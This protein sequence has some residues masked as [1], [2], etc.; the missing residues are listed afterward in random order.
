MQVPTVGASVHPPLLCKG[1]TLTPLRAKMIYHMQ[2][3]RLAPKTQAAS[4]A[5]VAGLATF[6][7]R[8]PDQLPPAQMRRSL[9]PGLVDRHRA[10]SSCN[11]VACGLRFFSTKTLGWEPL[12]L[13]L[14]PRTGRSQ[15]PQVLSVEE[16]QRLFTSAK[17]PRNRVLLMTTSAAGLRVSAVVRLKRTD[18]ASERGLSR[19]EP[20]KGRKD[21]STRLSTRLLTDLRASWKLSRPAPWLLTGLD[22]HAPLP[23]GTAQNISYHAP[24]TAGITHGHGIHTL[25][26]GCATHRLEAGVDV[27]TIQMVL[28]HQA[29]DTPARSLRITRQHLATIRSPCDLLPCGDPPLPTPEEPHAAAYHRLPRWGS[30]APAQRPTVGSRR[31]LPPLWCDLPPYPSRIALAAAG[32]ARYR[33]LPDG[34]ARWARR[35]LSSL[36][37]RAVRLSCLSPSPRSEVSDVYQDAVG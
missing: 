36:W 29:L 9:H 8:S 7:H 1:A 17:N 22:P 23:I 27:R 15:L 26:H 21:R 11:H 35:T 24:R 28:G 25:R 18:I 3:E 12:S 10:W 4:V 14:P 6:S 37:V 5:A 32:D 19:V 13:N 16:L 31:Y 34:A 2:L 33:D 20:G 30:P